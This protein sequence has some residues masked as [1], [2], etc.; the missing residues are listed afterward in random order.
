MDLFITS[1]KFFRERTII[2]IYV[3]LKCER[4]PYILGKVKDCLMGGT[5]IE[6]QFSLNPFSN[7]PVNLDPIEQ[8]RIK[9]V[10]SQI[11]TPIYSKKWYISGVGE[12]IGKNRTQGSIKD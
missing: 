2:Q 5:I 3:C 6:F 10:C 4:F 9:A 1:R 7:P 11:E 12:N 8:G